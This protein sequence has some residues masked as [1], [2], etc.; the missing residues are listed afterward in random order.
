MS[1]QRKQDLAASSAFK[2]SVRIFTNNG[3][4][5]FR[6]HEEGDIGP[7]RYESEASQ[8]LDKFI[9]DIIA[10]EHATTQP[11]KP[12]LRRFAIASITEHIIKP[13]H[14]HH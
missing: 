13:S 12:H 4:W 3:L 7:F 6:T 14:L 2:R 10:K 5:Y 1:S 8:M 9:A 11:Q